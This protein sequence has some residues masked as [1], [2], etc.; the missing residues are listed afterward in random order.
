MMGWVHPRGWRGS[1]TY[2]HQEEFTQ[3]LPPKITTIGKERESLDD[4]VA[5]KKVATERIDVTL[6]NY[7]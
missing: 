4:S 2:E 5:K 6:K 3:E 1:H 7:P